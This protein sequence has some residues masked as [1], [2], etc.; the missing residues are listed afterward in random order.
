[1]AP[2][3]EVVAEARC[4]HFPRFSLGWRP[5]PD[6][7]SRPSVHP[8]IGPFV[9]MATQTVSGVGQVRTD[10]RS[11]VAFLLLLALSVCQVNHTHF[12][13]YPV[14]AQRLL[15]LLLVCLIG[16]R[17]GGLSPILSNGLTTSGSSLIIK[18]R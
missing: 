7:S 13:L 15:P 3:G 6:P 1:M 9:H 11:V 2:G 5:A 17:A 18:P 16:I 12:A 8:S 4:S 10:P 14:R